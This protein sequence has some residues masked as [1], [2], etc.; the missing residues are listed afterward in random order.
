MEES[1]EKESARKGMY[2]LYFLI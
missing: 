2:H 1:L